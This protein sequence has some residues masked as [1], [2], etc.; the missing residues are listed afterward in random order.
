ME[1]PATPESKQVTALRPALGALATLLGGLVLTEVLF[2]SS[3]LGRGLLAENHYIAKSESFSSGPGADVVVVG[4]SRILHGFYPR[5]AELVVNAERGERIVAYNAGLS[6]APPM[7]HLAWV[8]RALTH[9]RRRPRVVALS[10][11]PYMFGTRIANNLARE[12]L[13]TMYRARDVA[14]MLRAGAGI[15]DVSSV[16]VG[17]ASHLVRFRPRVLEILFRSGRVNEPAGLGEQGYLNNG[18]VDAATQNVRALGRAEGYHQEIHRPEARLENEHRGYFEECL[19]ELRDAG[20]RTLVLNS[21][22]SS[23]IARRYTPDT[24][25]EEHLRYVRAQSARFGAQWVD[26][27]QT[28][29]VDDTDYTDGDHLSGTGAERWTAWLTHNYVVPA[30]GGTNLRPDPR[31]RVLYDFDRGPLA[32]WTLEDLP[33]LVTGGSLQHQQ[34]VTGMVGAGFLTTYGRSGVGD[35]QAGSATSPEFNLDGASLTLRV[36]GGSN[37]GVAVE[38]L[39]NGAVVRTA[40]GRDDEALRLTRW[41]VGPWR[42]QPARLRVRDE[43]RS[44]WGHLNLDDVELCP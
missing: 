6:G 21:P 34:A 36:S 42:G 14:G 3:V 20:V 29:A 41:D 27:M 39:V 31:C 1:P 17:S 8:R 12:S 26:A 9:P 16:L 18:F 33:N 44:P 37:A 22:S 25:Y 2:R 35:L 38:L 23:Q 28:P 4:D 11:S 13:G 19:R 15:D 43:A 40:R 5:V 32:G 24:L 10:I 30:L 7:A